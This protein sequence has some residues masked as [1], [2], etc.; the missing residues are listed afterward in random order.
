MFAHQL[1]QGEAAKGSDGRLGVMRNLS[2][3]RSLLGLL[4]LDSDAAGASAANSPA[5]SSAPQQLCKSRLLAVCCMS[6]QHSAASRNLGF[7]RC[8]KHCVSTILCCDPLC[9]SCGG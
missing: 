6:K 4:R 3:P 7:G 2:T 9:V 8:K 5:C 1:S